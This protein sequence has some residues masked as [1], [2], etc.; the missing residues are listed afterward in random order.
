MM[1]AMVAGNIDIGLNA[2]ADMVMIAKGA[3]FTAIAAL[4]GPPDLGL[5]VRPDGPVRNVDDLKGRKVSASG[6]ASATG[7]LVREVSRQQGWGPDGIEIVVATGTASW[8]LLKTREIDGVSTDVGTILLAEKNGYGRLLLRYA[9]RV[10]HFHMNVLFATKAL[11][12]RNPD[13][14]RAFVGAWFDTIAYAR[15]HRQETI[16]IARDVIGLDEDIL[17]RLYD[18]Q[19]ALYSDT[20]AFDPAA[21]AVLSRSYVELKLVEAEPDMTKLYTEAFLPRR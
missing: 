1:Q 3:P 5:G 18:T 8:A 6:L 12:D 15:T 16:R 7:W 19:M 14:V 2:G 11:I 4:S 20:G 13:T 9:E 21:L 17:G 10:P